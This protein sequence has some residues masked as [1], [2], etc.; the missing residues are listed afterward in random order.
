MIFDVTNTKDDETNDL[1]TSDERMFAV[2]HCF[3]FAVSSFVELL[4]ILL[5]CSSSIGKNNFYRA[6]FVAR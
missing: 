1:N 4:V 5:L 6:W 2:A 3:C